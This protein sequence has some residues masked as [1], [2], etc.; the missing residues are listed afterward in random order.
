MGWWVNGKSCGDWMMRTLPRRPN[1]YIPILGI[2]LNH[3][4]NHPW[5]VLDLSGRLLS[6]TAHRRHKPLMLV[7]LIYGMTRQCRHVSPHDPHLD[8]TIRTL[9]S[10]LILVGHDF[11]SVLF[12]NQIRPVIAPSCEY[13]RGSTWRPW[14]RASAHLVLQET[15]RYGRPIPGSDETCEGSL[16]PPT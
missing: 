12:S 7:S 1:P 10:F 15:P 16:S 2:T 5:L 8:R 13:L 14:P 4:S 11:K 6:V 9:H 3:S